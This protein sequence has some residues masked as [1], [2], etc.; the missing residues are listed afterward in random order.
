MTVPVIGTALLIVALVLRSG[1]ERPIVRKSDALAVDTRKAPLSQPPP[2]RPKPSKPANPS[3]V[4]R[5]TDRARVRAMYQSYR[6]AVASNN[7]IVQDA[8]RPALIQ[9]HEIALLFAQEELD[10]ARESY[11]RDIAQKTL[12]TLRR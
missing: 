9:E 11:D 12:E 1:D 2:P 10:R 7:Q 5:S 8:L 3:E 4:A 6:T